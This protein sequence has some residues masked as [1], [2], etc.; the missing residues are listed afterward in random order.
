MARAP[1]QHPACRTHLGPAT[2][3]RT[4]SRRR[5]PA[6]SRSAKSGSRTVGG[7]PGAARQISVHRRAAVGPGPSGRR[8]GAR[9]RPSARQG[10]GL[11]RARRRAR[12]GDRPR[13]HPRG[14]GR[15]RCAPPRST[16][17]SSGCS[18]GGRSRRRRL[19]FAGRH[20]PRDRRRPVA[21]RD[22][23]ESRPHLPALRLWPAARAP[24]R[25]GGGGG[26]PRALVAAVR[27]GRGRARPHILAAGG[28]FVLERWTGGG[29]GAGEAVV[30][31]L[32]GGGP[33]DGEALD[34][35]AVWRV[36]GTA[37]TLDGRGRPARRLS[38]RRGAAR[39]WSAGVHNSGKAR[40]ASV[41]WR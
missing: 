33:I 38:G 28:A 35:G 39:A 16:A 25:R 18:T 34:A 41:D 30:V 12:R 27:A 40:L 2:T 17:A 31:P 11:V 6:P 5:V 13:P 19:L 20:G 21:D 29:R 15:K 14:V 7:R 10:R 3:C 37:S 9:P 32:A 4:G 36:D 8:G 22:P 1:P 23:A 24:P 26:R